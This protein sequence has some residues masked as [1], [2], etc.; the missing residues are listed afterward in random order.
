MK[1]AKLLTITLVVASLVGVASEKCYSKYKKWSDESNERIAQ[2]NK[3]LEGG[4]PK[5][6]KLAEKLRR[7]M[8]P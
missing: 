4:M 7:E 5:T 2:A 3:E 6:V 8:K 1:R